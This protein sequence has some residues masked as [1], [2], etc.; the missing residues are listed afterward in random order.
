MTIKVNDMMCKMCVKHLEDALKKAGVKGTVSLDAKTVTV[1]DKDGKKAMAA[2]EK[3][4]Y[5]P[6]V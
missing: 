2:I 1:D 3:A 6:T 5:T 4:G